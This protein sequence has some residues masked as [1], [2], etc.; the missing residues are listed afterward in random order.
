[1]RAGLALCD[2]TSLPREKLLQVLE[3][4]A[5][6][7]PMFRGKGPNMIKGVYTPPA[8]PLKHAQKDMRLALAMGA[9]SGL[10]LPTAATAN[11]QYLS[12]LQAH[13]DHDFSAVHHAARRDR[14][15]L[16]SASVAT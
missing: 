16:T 7:N 6:A 15:E 10:P 9:A 4:G 14:L 11:Q 12:V 3:L 1:M 5:M 13:G 2:A 8:F